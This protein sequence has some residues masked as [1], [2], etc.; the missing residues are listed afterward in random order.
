M[1]KVI[2]CD[3]DELYSQSV[4]RIQRKNVNCKCY[5]SLFYIPCIR[6]A[7]IL[8]SQLVSQS[9]LLVLVTITLMGLNCICISVSFSC[10]KDYFPLRFLHVLY[11]YNVMV[12]N[13]FQFHFQNG[14]RDFL[15]LIPQ[16]LS[17][18]CEK[19][20][21]FSAKVSFVKKDY[22]R[23]HWDSFEWNYKFKKT[24]FI[25]NQ[26]YMKHFLQF[27]NHYLME[28]GYIP[29]SDGTIESLRTGEQLEEAIRNL[30]VRCFY[31]VYVFMGKWKIC[32]RVDK[33]CLHIHFVIM[34]TIF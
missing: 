31:Y 1:V 10:K 15:F 12:I 23:D 7:P 27:Q 25:K 26:I 33:T 16:I 3:V 20:L 18:L 2:V 21:I 19:D 8:S 28:F 29:K 13:H 11:I 4:L 32:F 24:V 9:K 34:T 30:Q 6:V 22:V 5:L 14:E 17:W